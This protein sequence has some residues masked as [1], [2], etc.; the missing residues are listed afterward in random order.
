MTQR[1]EN[2]SPAQEPCPGSCSG[3]DP[4]FGQLMVSDPATFMIEKLIPR[5]I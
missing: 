3:G 4:Y 5:K 2:R 1:E